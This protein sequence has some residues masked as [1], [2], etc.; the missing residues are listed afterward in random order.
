[1]LQGGGYLPVWAIG[2][3]FN[4]V[5]SLLRLAQKGGTRESMIYSGILNYTVKTYI[6]FAQIRRG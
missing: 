5:D 1:M 2:G 4:Y 6:L 3:V